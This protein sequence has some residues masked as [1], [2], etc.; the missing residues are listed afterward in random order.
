VAAES[1]DGFLKRNDSKIADLFA[2][3]F[4]S[5]VQCNK[6]GTESLTFDPYTCLR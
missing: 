1:W 5:H 6:C 3:Q 4:R 2:G